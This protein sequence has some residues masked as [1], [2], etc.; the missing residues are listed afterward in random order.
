VFGVHWKH[1]LASVSMAAGSHWQQSAAVPAA[2]AVIPL[3]SFYSAAALYVL[4]AVHEHQAAAAA[5][6][7]ALHPSIKAS[8]KCN[9]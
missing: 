7:T 4:P 9:S 5:V 2:V 1:H 8:Q 6:E 3:V